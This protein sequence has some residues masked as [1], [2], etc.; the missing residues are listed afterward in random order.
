M[1][2]M[3]QRAHRFAVQV[4]IR[5]AYQLSL[6]VSMSEF[7]SVSRPSRKALAVSNWIE[8]VITNIKQLIHQT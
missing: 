4:T 1:I 5:V 3:I 6:I 8:M 2:A 7:Q